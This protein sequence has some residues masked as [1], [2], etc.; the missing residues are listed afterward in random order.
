MTIAPQAAGQGMPPELAQLLMSGAGAGDAQAPGPAPTPD[1]NPA[2]ADGVDP[3]EHLRAA[4]EHAQA[5]LVSEPDDQDSQA[6]AKL[7]SGLYQI[8][9]N[10][11]KEQDQALGNPA[12]AKLLRRT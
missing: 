11:Q 8:L 7:V 5:A 1:Q 6:L 9:A 3:L 12:T 2:K 10:R 4:I